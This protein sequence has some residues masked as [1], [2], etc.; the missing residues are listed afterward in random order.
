M[1]L[2]EYKNFSQW[3]KS[4]NLEEKVDLYNIQ[5]IKEQ[6]KPRIRILDTSDNNI[7]ILEIFKNG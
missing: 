5:R 4:L 7:D 3:F 6:F 2:K 1:N